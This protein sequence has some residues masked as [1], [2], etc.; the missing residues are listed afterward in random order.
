MIMNIKFMKRLI[1]YCG[2]YKNIYFEY[3]NV[4]RDFLR[5]VPIYA[6]E[7]GT[8]STE[9]CFYGS[10]MTSNLMGFLSLT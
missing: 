8:K 4:L 6:R 9:L 10:K 1:I 2:K 3:T 7:S 5:H